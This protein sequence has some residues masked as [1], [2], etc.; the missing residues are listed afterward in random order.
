[1]TAWARANI[2]A[3]ERIA[4]EPGGIFP[5]PDHFTIDQVD[6]LG[7]HA[8]DF[9]RSRGI[10]WLLSSGRDRLVA[11][12]RE[13]ADVA[14]NQAALASAAERV[15][16]AG[17][18]AI[19]RIQDG[20]AWEK[21]VET[22]LA[23]GDRRGARDILERAAQGGD[24][25]L[26]WRRLAGFRLQAADTAGAV[27]AYARAS[28]IDSTDGETCLALGVLQVDGGCYED[29]V[30]SLLRAE[31]HMPRQEPVVQ[32]NLAV[33]RLSLARA[34]LREER[35]EE[36]LALWASALASARTC[37]RFA[38]SDPNLGG[39]ESLVLRMGDRWGFVPPGDRS[40]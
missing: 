15:W 13:Y 16:G 25:A 28:D 21:D 2:P 29:A 22:A 14:S 4:A 3:S 40:R 32:Y 18:Y 7:R 30:R 36:A 39:I 26:A 11:G 34:R 38:G 19:Y 10:R 27:A 9:Y 37:V 8:P 24:D 12:R 33:A 20:E 31:R 1:M 35:R 6:F 23:A 17:A 5:D